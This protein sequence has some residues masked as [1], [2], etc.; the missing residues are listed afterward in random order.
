MVDGLN[1][2]VSAK[3]VPFGGLIGPTSGFPAKS[4]RHKFLTER[5][6]QKISTYY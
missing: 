2:A 4:E 3:E 1:D 6:M 5:D